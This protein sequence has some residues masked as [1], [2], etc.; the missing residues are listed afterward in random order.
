MGLAKT[1]NVTIEIKNPCIHCYVVNFW[2]Q[3]ETQ[4]ASHVASTGHHGCLFPY[5]PHTH[6]TESKNSTS[7]WHWPEISLHCTQTSPSRV[8]ILDTVAPWH[9]SLV[10]C[11]QSFGGNSIEAS[12]PSI[13]YYA[14]LHNLNLYTSSL[15]DN[16]HVVTSTCTRRHMHMYMSCIQGNHLYGAYCQEHMKGRSVHC[17]SRI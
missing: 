13:M 15:Q 1:K 14:L 9:P 10:G 11:F 16:L 7:N 8:Y 12:V 5:S 6:F 2:F 17:I 4:H 3:K